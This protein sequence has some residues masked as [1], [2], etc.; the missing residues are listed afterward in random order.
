MQKTIKLLALV[1]TLP[2][3]YGL[4]ALVDLIFMA[5]FHKRL[6]TDIPINQVMYVK[7]AYIVVGIIFSKTFS[8]ITGW[9]GK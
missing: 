1:G 9:D 4:A 5:C 8:M 3:I 6:W 2:I 7:C